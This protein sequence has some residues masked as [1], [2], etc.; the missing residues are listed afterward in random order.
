MLYRLIGLLHKLFKFLKNRKFDKVDVIYQYENPQIFLYFGENFCSKRKSDVVKL[1]HNHYLNTIN[2][3][4]HDSVDAW[5]TLIE[6]SIVPT[7]WKNSNLHN[8]AYSLKDKQLKLSSW[9]WTSAAICRYY[10]SKNDLENVI[11]ICNAFLQRQLPSGGWIVRTDIIK[12]NPT[13]ILAPNDSAYIAANALV[14]GY[15]LTSDIKYLQAAEN[16]ANW[17]IKTC[18]NDGM[19]YIG[20]DITNNSWLKEVNIVDTGFTAVLFVELYKLT[21]NKVYYDFVI[22]FAESYL[23]YFYDPKIGYMYSS[24]DSNNVGFGGYFTRGQAWA[25]EGLI[26]IFSI[27]KNIRYYNIIETIIDQLSKSQ[28]KDGSW[29]YNLSRPFYGIDNKAVSVIANSIL[30]WTTL[31]KNMKYLNCAIK[32]HNWCKKSTVL[33]LNG[34]GYIIDYSLEGAISYDLYSKVGMTY[35]TSYALENEILI[36]E[37]K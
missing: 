21:S 30:T 28:L 8:T 12:G 29:P 33:K 25:L 24:T 3:H 31:T 6:S 34:F 5:E 22:Q 27:T 23:N 2:R 20:F 4:F 15:R 19:V 7:G 11:R 16:C 17:I 26:S 14:N 1:K 35:S 37:L 18:K 9:I 13:E 10:Y 36:K 32:A